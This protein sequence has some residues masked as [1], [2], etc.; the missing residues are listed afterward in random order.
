M[1]LLGGIPTWRLA[2]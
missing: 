2:T 1:Q